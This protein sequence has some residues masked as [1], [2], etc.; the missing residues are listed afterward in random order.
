M[1]LRSPK[2]VPF[3]DASIYDIQFTTLPNGD[4]PL[5]GQTVNTGGI[6]TASYT[7]AY[8]IQNASGPWQ[9]ILCV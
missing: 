4:S 3:R 9:G 2:A 1:M 6:V 8:Y 5:N 7:G